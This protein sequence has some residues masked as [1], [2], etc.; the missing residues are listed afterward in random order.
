MTLRIHHLSMRVHADNARRTS[1]H[2]EIISL[3]T[4]LGLVA[5]FFVLSTS[6]V[7]YVNYFL[8]VVFLSSSYLI[9][10]SPLISVTEHHCFIYVSHIKSLATITRKP[11][12]KKKIDAKFLTSG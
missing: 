11:E 8:L 6:T 12:D 2:V 7:R 9:V 10:D 4:D 5:N 1:K 3:P